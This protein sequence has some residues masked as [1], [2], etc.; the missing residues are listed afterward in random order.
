MTWLRI[1]S[2]EAG[3]RL[4]WGHTRHG[5]RR[6]REN[7]AW[8]PWGVDAWSS[9]DAKPLSG[10]AVTELLLLLQDFLP[11]DGPAPTAISPTWDGGVQADWELG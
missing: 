1:Q 10:W 3:L 7:L 5:R 4:T 11:P 9:E 6:V 2:S 8:L